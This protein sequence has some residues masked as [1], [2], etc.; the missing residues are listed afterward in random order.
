[1]I[2]VR[3]DKSHGEYTRSGTLPSGKVYTSFRGAKKGMG[4]PRD[5]TTHMKSPF[6]SAGKMKE[7]TDGH[8]ARTRFGKTPGG[9]NY[10]SSRSKSGSGVHKE[11]TAF[12][13]GGTSQIQKT[14][15]SGKSTSYR[16]TGMT[17]GGRE[18]AAYKNSDGSKQTIVGS[19]KGGKMKAPH[20]KSTDSSGFSQKKMVKGYKTRPIANSFRS[21]VK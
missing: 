1:M 17:P 10:V 6:Q 9:R 4:Q 20:A 8:V 11:T 2:P 3:R 12:R 21:G 14:T 15:D 19:Q 16:K 7:T 18:Y 5:K 13:A